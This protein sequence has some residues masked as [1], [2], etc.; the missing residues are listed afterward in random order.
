MPKRTQLAPL[1]TV[2]TALLLV[3]C[4]TCSPVIETQTIRIAPPPALMADCPPPVVSDPKTRDDMR[5]LTL[6]LA[7]WGQSCRAK[8][9][10]LR[11]WVGE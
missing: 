5:A 9:A 2:A 6:A 8:L 1:L 3:G 11:A 4:E 10:G 7:Q